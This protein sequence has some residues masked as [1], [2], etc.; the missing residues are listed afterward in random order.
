MFS[1]TVAFVV[2]LTATRVIVLAGRDGSSAMHDDDMLDVQ[3][4]H[5]LAVPRVSGAGVAFGPAGGQ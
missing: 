1:L 3:K 4:F 2:S 5:A